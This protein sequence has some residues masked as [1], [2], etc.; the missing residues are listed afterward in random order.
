[1]K[2]WIFI[3]VSL[4][5]LS[6]AATKRV[7]NRKK[8]ANAKVSENDLASN[9]SALW[10]KVNRI[11]TAGGAGGVQIHV[12]GMGEADTHMDDHADGTHIHLHMHLDDDHHRRHH[13]YHDDHHGMHH[14]HR[15]ETQEY[16]Y[17]VC[18]VHPNTALPADQQQPINGTIYF[19]QKHGKHLEVKVRLT[20]FDMSGDHAGHV[21][22]LH[23]HEFGDLIDGCQSLGSHFNPDGK[24]HGGPEG[25][26]RH[27]GDY[28]NIECDVH[29]ETYKTF[30]DH[31]TDLEGHYG[32]LGK[33]LV[34]HK[35]A[36]DLSDSGSAGDR[37]ACCVVVSATIDHW[38]TIHGEREEHIVVDDTDHHE[39]HGVHHHN[40]QEYHH[41]DHHDDHHNLHHTDHHD[42]HHDDHHG[43]HHDHHHDDHHDGHH[44]D[45][46][47]HQHVDHH[48]DHHDHHHDDHHDG[49]H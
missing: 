1:M 29:G 31:H 12:H 10:E 4:A 15:N 35:T 11:G 21:H 14:G 25:E 37:L 48:G 38:D 30:Y 45:H 49:H 36:D 44:G 32:V 16:E 5:L 20:G 28:G 7:K 2:L 46:H 18:H 26:H 41:G 19:R 42:D 6:L 23:V 3:L 39:L 13:D 34:I 24:E 43:D 22:G 27:S 47:D 33:G 40:H 17:A 9:I 8:A